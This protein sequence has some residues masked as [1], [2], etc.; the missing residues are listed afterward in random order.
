MVD[1]QV[2]ATSNL[3]DHLHQEVEEIG[4]KV[5]GVLD[6]IVPHVKNT[7]AEVSS[8]ADGIVG[9]VGTMLEEV[10]GGLRVVVEDATMAI[11]DKAEAIMD[12]VED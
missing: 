8:M 11:V 3:K 4:Q 12:V 6:V 10:G 9:Q 7:E 5:K 1:G 2:A